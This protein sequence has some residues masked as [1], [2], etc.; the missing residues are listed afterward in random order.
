V[1]KEALLVLA[2]GADAIPIIESME[3]RRAGQGVNLLLARS[4]H[5]ETRNALQALGFVFA[6]EGDSSDPVL[7]PVIAPEGWCL[8]RMKGIHSELHDDQGRCRGHFS[9]KGSFYDRWAAFNLVPRFQICGEFSNSESHPKIAALQK[10]VRTER[11]EEIDLPVFD[12]FGF[13]MLRNGNVATTRRVVVEEHV[14][15]TYNPQQ[16]ARHARLPYKRFY[17]KDNA[18]GERVW[19]GRWLSWNRVRS[20]GDRRAPATLTGAAWLQKNFPNYTDVLAY[21]E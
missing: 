14:V 12:T 1:T 20:W 9:Y 16:N 3:M 10:T 11:V 17:V 8:A 2:V 13:S 5:A 18:S 4:M 7:V 19:T 15:N 21:W 6:P